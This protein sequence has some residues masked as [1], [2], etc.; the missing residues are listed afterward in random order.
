[1][2]KV[3]GVYDRDPVKHADARR[4]NRLSYRQVSQES[5]QVMDETAVTLCKENAIPVIVFNI[6]QKGNILKASVGLPTQARGIG[7]PGWRSL[8]QCVNGDIKWCR[9]TCVGGRIRGH[10]GGRVGGLVLRSVVLLWHGVCRQRWGSPLAQ[11][12]RTTMT[13]SPRQ[14][15]PPDASNSPCLRISS[16]NENSYLCPTWAFTQTPTAQP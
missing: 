5:L 14:R 3:D 9:R 12:C 7:C 11:W 13:L 8:P 10:V 6:S 16:L 2:T 15:S 1:A 4:Y